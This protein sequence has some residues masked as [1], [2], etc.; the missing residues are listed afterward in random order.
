MPIATLKYRYATLANYSRC[1][2]GSNG[3]IFERRYGNV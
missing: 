2:L 3:R 1:V